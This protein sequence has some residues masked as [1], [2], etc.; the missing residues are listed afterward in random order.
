MLPPNTK[1]KLLL[2]LSDSAYDIAYIV[3]NIHQIKQSG[4]FPII[5]MVQWAVWSYV[6]YGIFRKTKPNLH[7]LNGILP[8]CA[9]FDRFRCEDANAC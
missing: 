8:N 1:K 4:V 5:S 6:I 7:S 2:L 9:T 3:P